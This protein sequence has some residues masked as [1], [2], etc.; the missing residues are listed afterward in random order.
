[1]LRES[2][3]AV[4]A[5][6]PAWAQPHYPFNDVGF[7]TWWLR[8]LYLFPQEEQFAI[9]SGLRQSVHDP[10]VQAEIDAFLSL[11]TLPDS[12]DE[13]QPAVD[14]PVDLRNGAEVVQFSLAKLR[15]MFRANP[16]M[17]TFG[18]TGLT[19]AAGKGAWVVAQGFLKIVF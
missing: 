11:F 14:A 10:D 6:G 1:M 17:V 13:L 16:W 8:S 15:E 2:E 7:V 3:L 4:E 18:V 9:A 5:P 19:L 12:P